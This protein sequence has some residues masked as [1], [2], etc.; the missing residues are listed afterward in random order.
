MREAFVRF[1][2]N[3][4]PI[5]DSF[6]ESSYGLWTA[7]IF[8]QNFTFKNIHNAEFIYVLTTEWPCVKDV[9]KFLSFA[10]GCSHASCIGDVTS[11]KY[12]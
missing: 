9:E 7:A 10:A 5:G 11:N 12:L 6:L 3:A 4:L 2:Q 8:R 1:P